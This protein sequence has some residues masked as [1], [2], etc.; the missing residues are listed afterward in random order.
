MQ[1]F[2]MTPLNTLPNLTFPNN[3]PI[4]MTF[5][6]NNPV[7][8]NM[9]DLSLPTFNANPIGIFGGSA[10]INGLMQPNFPP[11]DSRTTAYFGG[12]QNQQFSGLSNP[13]LGNIGNKKP[14][15]NCN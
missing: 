6:T 1:P 13:I 12:G 9:M 4:N 15:D 2:Q 8:N 14:C 3:N 5:P 7:S 11:L 10:D